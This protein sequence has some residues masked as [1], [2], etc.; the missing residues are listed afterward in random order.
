MNMSKSCTPP[1]QPSYTESEAAHPR[2]REYQLYRQKMTQ[3]LVTGD[4]FARWIEQIERNENGFET[5]FE[6]T[7]LDAVL[8]PGWYKNVFEKG[9]KMPRSNGPF[10]S[11]REA[12]L[13]V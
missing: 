8:K 3:Q 5:V 1:T 13:S 6:V 9:R 10:G 7:S 2:F 12:D 11:K 4:S